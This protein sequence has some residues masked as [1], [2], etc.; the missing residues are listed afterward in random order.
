MSDELP[1]GDQRPVAPLQP[2]DRP[3]AEIDWSAI[4]RAPE[5]QELVHRRRAFV[6]PAT[7]FF[8]SWYMGFIVLTAVAPDFMGERVYEGLTVGYVLAL[9][10]FLMVLVLGIW[11]LRKSDR[12][13][14]PLAA[15]VRERYGAADLDARPAAPAKAREDRFF[16]SRHRPPTTT[17]GE[18]RS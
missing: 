11:Y 16:R 17:T 4:E 2:A 8:L 9:T 5:F 15:R 13:F 1:P 10:Q 6:I 14:D 18:P 3:H 7:A 12:E